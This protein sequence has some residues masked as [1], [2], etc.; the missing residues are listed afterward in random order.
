MWIS[1]LNSFL[2]SSIHNKDSFSGDI[3][4]RS[5]SRGNEY[6]VVYK[7]RYPFIPSSLPESLE[8]RP[9]LTPLLISVLSFYPI[10]CSP[11][12]L[13]SS[14]TT[15]TSSVPTLSPFTFSLAPS[16]LSSVS[17]PS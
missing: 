2:T 17:Y 4:Y 8:F 10:P 12:A 15:S 5:M 1:Y 6:F 13:Q 14:P 11:P 3:F 9:S 16:T 7:V